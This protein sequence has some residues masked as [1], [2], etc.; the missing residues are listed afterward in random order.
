MDTKC[1][2][3]LFSADRFGCCIC[4]GPKLN[5]VSGQCQ[6]RI[7]DDCLYEKDNRRICMKNCPVCSYE[8]SFPVKR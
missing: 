8:D 1:N 6:H 3:S 2:S 7:C 5:M 4:L